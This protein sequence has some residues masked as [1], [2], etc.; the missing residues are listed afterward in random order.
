MTDDLFGVTL[1]TGEKDTDNDIVDKQYW[2]HH[3]SLEQQRITM[4][5]LLLVSS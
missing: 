2:Y 4:G 3:S 5:D 1:E